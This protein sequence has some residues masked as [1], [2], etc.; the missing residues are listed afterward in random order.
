MKTIVK[1]FKD[2]KP[3]QFFWI[4][5]L[6]FAII[7]LCVGIPVIGEYIETKY[8]TRVPS[9]ILATGIMTFALIIAQCGVILDTV[10]KQHRESYELNVLRYTQIEK[11]KNNS[12]H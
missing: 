7:G 10:V 6:V 4:I 1:M 9:A 8:I 5:A 2:Y 12:E 11:L 3:R